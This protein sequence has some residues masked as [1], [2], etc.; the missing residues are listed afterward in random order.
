MIGRSTHLPT[1]AQ[2]RAATVARTAVEDFIV[3]IPVDQVADVL[4]AALVEAHGPTLAEHLA[5]VIGRHAH[6]AGR[7]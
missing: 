2:Q 3:H 1:Q 7:A 6:M 4:A 5:N